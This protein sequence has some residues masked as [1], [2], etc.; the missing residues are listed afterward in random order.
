MKFSIKKYENNPK[1]C[2]VDCLM[3]Y[4]ERT[5]SFRNSEHSSDPVL[6]T[7]I[8]P[9]KGI[10]SNTVS[11]WIKDVMSFAGIDTTKFKAHSA[12]GQVQVKLLETVCP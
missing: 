11:N 10:S 4:F 8:R 12:R 3:E 7:I 9:H 1:L 2:V 5:E 6:R